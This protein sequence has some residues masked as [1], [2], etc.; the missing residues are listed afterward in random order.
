MPYRSLMEA[1][2]TLNSP[3]V[4]SLSKGLVSMV[5]GQSRNPKPL[6]SEPAKYLGLRTSSGILS[7]GA[8]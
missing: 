1:L 5:S 7:C 2:Y 8:R 6:K 3:P 4:V